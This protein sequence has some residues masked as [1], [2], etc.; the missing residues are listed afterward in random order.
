[1]LLP[2]T[3]ANNFVENQGAVARVPS[4]TAA[5]DAPMGS[6]CS[7]PRTPSCICTQRFKAGKEKDKKQ[8]PSIELFPLATIFYHTAAGEK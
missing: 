3:K 6:V 1:M 8:P 5:E 7:N 2:A 4:A